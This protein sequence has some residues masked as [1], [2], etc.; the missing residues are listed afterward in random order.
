MYSENRAL[1][2]FWYY[3]SK[4]DD[5]VKPYLTM[6]REQ[7]GT[8]TGLPKMF[9][10]RDTRRSANGLGGFRLLSTNF[11]GEK[12]QKQDPNQVGYH[13][14]DTVA[15]GAYPLDTHYGRSNSPQIL[16]FRNVSSEEAFVPERHCRSPLLH[17][18]QSSHHKFA[19][20]ARCWFVFPS[21]T[22]TDRQNDGPKLLREFS[23]PITP[24]RME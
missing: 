3:V 14:H 13:F 16:R 24:G 21:S 6:N 22:L 17:P 20:L 8:S 10:L 2:W 15:L 12:S 1:G 9:Y 7:V 4:A 18:F 23:N 19:Q 5:I 11:N